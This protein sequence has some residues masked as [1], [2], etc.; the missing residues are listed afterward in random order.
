MNIINNNPY[1][2]LGV[3]ANSPTK[4]R[5][6]N[7]GKLKAFLKVGKQVTFPL[8][9]SQFLPAASRTIESIADAKAKL[10]LPTDQIKYAQFWFLK[11]T[12]ID[13]VAF[14]NLLV[15]DMDKALQIWSKATNPSSL[16][17]RIVCSLI[18]KEYGT[19]CRLAEQLYTYSGYTAQL[20]NSVS[21][22]ASVPS[23]FAF[24]FLDTL[25]EEA[26][27]SVILSAITNDEWRQHISEKAVAPIIAH[28]Q[29][30]VNTAKAAR[31]KGPA[32]SYN[33][34][35]KLMNGTK[36]DLAHL[37]RLLSTTD[38]Q[39]QM[40]A[41]KLGLEILQCGINYFNDTDEPDAA[42]KAMPLQNYALTIVVGKMAKDRCQ[43]N[44]N[45]LK[46]IIAEL[47]PSQVSTEDKAIK[48][49]LREYNSLPD[50][51][52][53]A[54]NL[55]NNTKPHL[56]AIKHK[57][58]ASNA[59]YLKISTTVV[60]NAL[61]NVIAEV[62]EVQNDYDISIRLKLGLRLD[63][64]QLNK[65]KSVMR[66]AWNATTLMDSFDMEYE[67]KSKRYN[68]NRSTLKEMCE[69]L[70]IPTYP[71]QPSDDDDTLWERIKFI[72]ILVALGVIFYVIMAICS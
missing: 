25:C 13:N 44:V 48:D 52:V 22:G 55:L 45:I 24:D 11:V 63:Y 6:A 4:E 41:D 27:T 18:R 7:E 61:S 33:A 14:N 30:A 16:Q 70:G 49:E 38:L 20:V 69:K 32:E 58:G 29:S 57:L 71:S 42:T 8:D 10:T 15:G 65:I 1:R 67:F 5:V 23:S 56:Q 36:D 35:V 62:N 68:P 72:F 9:L 66:S 53:Y 37:R 54:V 2:I 12:P 50:K 31:G 60:G 40:I 21:S 28:I 59:Y 46:K 51:I 19:A 3:Y 64:S 34:G 26:G 47:P 17:N 39:Y 43:E